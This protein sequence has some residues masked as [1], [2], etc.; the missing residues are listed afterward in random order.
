MTII[1]W[2]FND[3]PVTYVLQW[4]FVAICGESRWILAFCFFQLLLNF[5]LACQTRQKRVAAFDPC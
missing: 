2:F 5:K 1:A 4:R 3:S